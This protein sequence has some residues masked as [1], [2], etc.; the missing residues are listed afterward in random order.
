MREKTRDM[1]LSIEGVSANVLGLFLPVCE[2]EGLYTFLGDLTLQ[3]EPMRL[4]YPNPHKMNENDK[5]L[6]CSVVKLLGTSHG[7]TEVIGKMIPLGGTSTL[8]QT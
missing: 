8:H 1:R 3:A 2:V 6:V 7:N 5:G 4:N